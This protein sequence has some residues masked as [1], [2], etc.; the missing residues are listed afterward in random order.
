MNTILNAI[1]S[2]MDLQPTIRPVIDLSD[3]KTGVNAIG[4]MFSGVQGI[5]VQSNINAVNLAMNNKLQ[6]G[7][8]NSIVSAIN[9]LNDGLANNRGDTYSINGIN[10]SEGT[11]AADAIHTLVRAIKM[12]GRS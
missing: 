2:D 12:E 1:G 8:N 5:G 3:V 4:G 7:Y 11:D 9:K 10:V 6:N